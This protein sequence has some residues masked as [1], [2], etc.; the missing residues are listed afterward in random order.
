MIGMYQ[1][2]IDREITIVSSKSVFK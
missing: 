1:F 2:V